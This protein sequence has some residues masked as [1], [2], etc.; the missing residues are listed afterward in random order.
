MVLALRVD[1]G[2]GPSEDP[3]GVVGSEV[4]EREGEGARPGL[5]GRGFGEEEVADEVVVGG[6]G[7]RVD[8]Y[9]VE[10]RRRIDP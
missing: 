6:G 9:P 5:P 4:D 8:A 10:L 1:F 7:R 2:A 3:E